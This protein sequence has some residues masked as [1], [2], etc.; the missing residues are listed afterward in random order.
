MYKEGSWTPLIIIIPPIFAELPFSLLAL[1]FSH[2]SALHLIP[3]T[4][5]QIDQILDWV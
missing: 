5:L 2:S 1:R 4:L 3:T